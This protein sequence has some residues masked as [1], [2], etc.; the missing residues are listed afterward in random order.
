MIHAADCDCDG[1]DRI[2]ALSHAAVEILVGSDAIA[3]GREDVVKN[4]ER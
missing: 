2:D 3:D 1:L 4:A